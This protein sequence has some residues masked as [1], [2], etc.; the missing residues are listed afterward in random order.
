MTLRLIY[1]TLVSTL[2]L[3]AYSQLVSASSLSF[4][5]ELSCQNAEVIRAYVIF[6]AN[7]SS[8]QGNS[9]R[10]RSLHPSPNI[11]P[12]PDANSSASTTMIA[13][14]YDAARVRLSGTAAHYIEGYRK[15]YPGTQP[16]HLHP[17]YVSSI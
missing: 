11:D 2:S 9:D 1:S 12:A 10:A 6:Q 14:T 7:Q 13:E 17:T 5:K 16:N 8:P 15:F 4:S 3:P